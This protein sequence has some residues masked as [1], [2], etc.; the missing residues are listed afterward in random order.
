MYSC[1]LGIYCISLRREVGVNEYY[2]YCYFLY[3]TE[4][5]SIVWT[6]FVVRAILHFLLPLLT[7]KFTSTFAKDVITAAKNVTLT[8]G[9][10]LVA[11]K[12]TLDK[13]EA[14]LVTIEKVINLVKKI[15][16]ALGLQWAQ[17]LQWVTTLSY[18]KNT[19]ESTI[20]LLLTSHWKV[21]TRN[22]TSLFLN[23]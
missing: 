6:I 1:H 13:L 3:L 7:A 22:Q 12:E 8:V 23:I 18:Q 2:Y 15:K 16:D 14:V 5:I 19:T 4:G 10:Y 21:I 17:E 20:N 9:E 11:V